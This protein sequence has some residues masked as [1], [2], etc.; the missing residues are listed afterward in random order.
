MGPFNLGMNNRLPDTALEVPK[1]GTFLRSAVNVDITVPGT[2]K[3]RGGFAQSLAGTD[4]H[5][6]WSDEDQAYMVDGTVL[7]H[8]TGAPGALGKSIVMSGLK[9]GVPVSFTRAAKDV[10]YSDGD[11]LY[12]LNGITYATLSVPMVNPEPIVSTTTG[13]L[14]AGVYQI[15]FAYVADDYRISGTTQPVQLELGEGLGIAITGIP[16]LPAGIA[17]VAIYMTEPNGDEL[18]LAT[19]TTENAVNIASTP[20][21]GG[22]CQT[23]NLLPMPGGLIVRHGSGRFFVAKGNMLL[24]SEP[25]STLYDPGKNFIQ[26]PT[27]VVVLE[28]LG[29]GIY[30]CTETAS[31]HFNGDI[32]NTAMNQVLPYG[33][34]P[35]T[36]GVY[37]DKSG[38]YWMSTRGLVRADESGQ[39]K[40]VQE[41]AVA[42]GASTSGAAMFREQDGN[43]QVIASLFGADATG[44]TAYSYMDAEIVRKGTVL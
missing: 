17:A 26:F 41:S 19:T 42:M 28:C 36:S 35:G 13:T 21:L 16:A 33:A 22:R 38:A 9:P 43:K 18:F 8:L 31:Y 10:V 6:L 4:V 39:V 30:V 12:K 24:Y 32:T 1:V 27:A 34:V 20:S 23:L 14:P 7:Y 29:A 25:F 44:A 40:N 5:S 11:T 3:R 15:C 37:P 2:I